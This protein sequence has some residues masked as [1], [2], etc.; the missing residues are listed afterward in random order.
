MSAARSRQESRI[1][2]RMF[3]KLS[4]PERGKFELAHTVDISCH[5]TRVASKSFWKPNEQLLVQSISG[6]LTS[7]ARVAHCQPVA[8]GTYTVGLELYYPTGGWTAF[9]DTDGRP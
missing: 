7:R 5:G 3:V 2:M 6:S 9:G 4:I 1:P 8:D